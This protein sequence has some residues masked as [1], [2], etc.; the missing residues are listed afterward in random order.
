MNTPSERLAERIIERLIQEKLLTKQEGKKILPKMA[1][2]KLRSEDW[3]L[4]IELSAP[5][6]T[7]A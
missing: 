2:G 1:E 7:K 3:R 5:R 6:E 4:P